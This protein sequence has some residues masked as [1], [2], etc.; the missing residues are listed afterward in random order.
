MIKTYSFHRPDGK[1]VPGSLGEPT[2]A[3]GGAGS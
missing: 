2:H 3:A 1:T